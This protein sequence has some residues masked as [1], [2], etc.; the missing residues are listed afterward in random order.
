MIYSFSTLFIDQLFYLSILWA[1]YPSP[2]ESAERRTE[3]G[4]DL[5]GGESATVT[6]VPLLPR[7]R[8]RRRRIIT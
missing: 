7:C 5:G 2:N 8:R 3:E 6:T 1:T 4:D